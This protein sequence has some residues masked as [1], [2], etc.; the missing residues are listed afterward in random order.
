MLGTDLEPLV[1]RLMQRGD[2]PTLGPSGIAQLRGLSDEEL[3]ERTVRDDHEAF[4]A[5]VERYKS[6]VVNL[7]ARFISDRDRA[8]E[9]SQEVFLRVFVH[10]ARYRPGGKFSTWLFTIAVNLAKNEIRYRVRHKREFSID[11]APEGQA[12]VVHTLRDQAE[13]A[14]ESVVREELEGVVGEAIGRLPPKYR[15]ALVLRDIEGLSY[16]EVGN[17]LNIPGGTVRSRINRA[18]LMLKEKLEPYM[19]RLEKR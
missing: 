10:R 7:V 12:S 11:A 14:D 1:Y 15:A 9:I 18:R 2:D 4:R 19:L 3:M 17:I 6:R 13:L 16:E 5:L 8:E